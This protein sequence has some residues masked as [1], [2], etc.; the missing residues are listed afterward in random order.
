MFVQDGFLCL[1]VTKHKLTVHGSEPIG[2]HRSGPASHIIFVRSGREA[3]RGFSPYCT[4]LN[5]FSHLFILN[6]FNVGHSAEA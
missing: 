5:T 2:F 6:E 3:S 1:T 4:G